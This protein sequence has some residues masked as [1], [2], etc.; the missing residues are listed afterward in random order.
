MAFRYL[1]S[2]VGSGGIADY[3]ER[4]QTT[5][6]RLVQRQRLFS[7]SLRSAAYD[8]QTATLEI[9]F[10]HG[11]IYQYFDV[12]PGLVDAFLASHSKGNFFNERIRDAYASS[13]LRTPHNDSPNR[14]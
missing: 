14:R 5:A 11:G 4:T 12:P 7:R 1:A 2:R 9:E 6:V 10:S 3:W 13:E 8:I